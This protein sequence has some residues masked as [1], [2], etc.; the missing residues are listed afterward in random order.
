[1]TE[2][3]PRW[4]KPKKYR[5]GLKGRPQPTCSL[6]QLSTEQINRFVVC[7]NC[8]RSGIDPEVVRLLFQEGLADTIH[9]VEIYRQY[10]Y[11]PEVSGIRTKERKAKWRK[12]NQ[13]YIAVKREAY[14]RDD[15][16]EALKRL[17]A[18]DGRQE[19]DQNE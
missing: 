13:E 6:L 4:P 19:E 17:M 2:E 14:R 10:G 15:R 18:G 9:R 11:D 7:G 12:E 1:M 3:V 16:I 8:S 5:T